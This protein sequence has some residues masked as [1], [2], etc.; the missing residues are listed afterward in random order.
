MK[1]ISVSTYLILIAGMLLSGCKDDSSADNGSGCLVG[2]VGCECVE[3]MCNAGLTCEQ[4][5]CVDP[6]AGSDSESDSEAG[7]EDSEK[8]TGVDTNPTTSDITMTNDNGRICVEGVV[9]GPA[10]N[11]DWADHWGAGVG[12]NLCQPDQNASNTKIALEECPTDLS[13]FAGVNVT[14]SGTLP[15]ALWVNFEDDITDEDNS[16]H[17]VETTDAADYLF[18][19]AKVWYQSEAERP[20]IQPGRILSVQFQVAAQLGSIE[21]FAFCIEN[22]SLIAGIAGVSDTDDTDS[23]TNTDSAVEPDT[24]TDT[25]V[26]DTDT[27]TDT[28]TSCASDSVRLLSNESNW[29]DG[30]TNTLGVQ[31]F[32]YTYSD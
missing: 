12:V 11:D 29:V 22:V 7:P 20:T 9:V 17:I 19:E 5:I 32:W 16:Y 6:F 31:G 15:T 24:E 23:D 27:D 13:D 25:A 10:S 30:C 18:T 2:T 4:N 28:D 26:A 3:S 21:E 1:K 8:D 14:F